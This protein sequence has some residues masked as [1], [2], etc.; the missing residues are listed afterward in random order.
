MQ[1]T[2]MLLL[3]VA[4]VAPVALAAETVPGDQWEVT[5]QMSMEGTP[6][7]LPENKVKVCSPKVW[8]EPP[9]AADERMRC[10]N[11]DFH[12]E[13]TKVT[14]KTTCAGP[15]AMTGVGEITHESDSAW[16]GNIK[17]TGG[18]ANMTLK[19]AGKRLGDCE[20]RK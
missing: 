7:K 9:G 1:R 3:A 14:W 17:F 6:V 5:S 15:P 18:E 11:S 20:A 13:G 10:T 19:L 4:V 8:T 16:S 12:Q 2:I